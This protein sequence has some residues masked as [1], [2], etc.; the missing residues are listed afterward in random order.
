MQTDSYDIPGAQNMIEEGIHDLLQKESVRSNKN[1]NGELQK[2]RIRNTKIQSKNN[3]LLKKKRKNRG[4]VPQ[5][6]DF[7]CLALA[8]R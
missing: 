4:K 8:K 6:T 2:I 1:S 3:F 7:C 5:K